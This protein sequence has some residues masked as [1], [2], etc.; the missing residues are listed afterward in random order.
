MIAALLTVSTLNGFAAGKEK[1]A[2]V[3]T[4]ST[5]VLNIERESNKV[6]YRL[7]YQSKVEGLVKVSIYNEQG[8]LLL[9]DRIVNTSGFARPY[10]FNALPLG[11]Y[12][13]QIE[14]ASGKVTK[15]IY[16]GK[17]S[18]I[19]SSQNSALQIK[20]EAVEKSAKY[21]LKV[22]GNLQEPLYV[23]I[24]NAN[25]IVVFSEE[26]SETKSFSKVYDLSKTGLTNMTFEVL[27]ASEILESATF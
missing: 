13:L 26:I 24:Y 10:N 17:E 2:N 6:V 21:E 4:Q 19:E 8:D 5:I 14:D 25:G 22:V 23:N 7:V 1:A 11:K 3:N 16:H 9:N 20:I 15:S 12:T 18:V 27:S